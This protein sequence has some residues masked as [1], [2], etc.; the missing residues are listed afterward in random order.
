MPAS[1][2]MTSNAVSADD[3]VTTRPVMELLS[4]R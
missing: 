4:A 2:P 1:P 3:D